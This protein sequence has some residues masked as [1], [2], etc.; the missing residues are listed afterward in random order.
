MALRSL[1]N[2]LPA[3]LRQ[4][5]YSLTPGGAAFRRRQAQNRGASTNAKPVVSA[6]VAVGAGV[7]VPDGA[8]T[9]DLA[10]H[11]IVPGLVCSHSHIGSVAGAD[12]SG[13]IQPEVRALDS[14]NGT[15]A[16]NFWSFFL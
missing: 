8:V 7:P 15:Y 1:A 9:V 13:P 2:R 11:T 6:K 10:G 4:R 16:F 3:P 14:I 5:A 12:S